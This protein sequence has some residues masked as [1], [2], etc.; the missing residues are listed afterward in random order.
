M[1]IAIIDPRT[2]QVAG[3]QGAGIKRRIQPVF[4][5]SQRR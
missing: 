5:S 2:G 1:Q 4:L 3:L